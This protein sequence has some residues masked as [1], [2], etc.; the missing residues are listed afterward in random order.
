MT[1]DFELYSVL[2]SV[3]NVFTEIIRVNLKTGFGEIVDT[4]QKSHTNHKSRP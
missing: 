1:F 2:V 4:S 3:E